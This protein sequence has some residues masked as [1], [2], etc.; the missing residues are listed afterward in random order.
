MICLTEIRLTSS[1]VRNEN[2]ML[3]TVDGNG[4]AMFMMVW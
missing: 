3:V 2:E 4:F 1:E